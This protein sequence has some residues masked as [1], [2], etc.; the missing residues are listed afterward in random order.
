MKEWYVVKGTWLE[1]LINLGVDLSYQQF[2]PSLEREVVEVVLGWCYELLAMQQQHRDQVVEVRE[3]SFRGS[4]QGDG[5]L[6]IGLGKL[7][8]TSFEEL[9]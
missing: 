9:L 7:T 6:G 2:I 5:G 1:G 4:L 8:S 3:F